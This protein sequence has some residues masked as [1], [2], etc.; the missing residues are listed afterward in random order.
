MDRIRRKINPNDVDE[1]CRLYDWIPSGACVRP[2]AAVRAEKAQLMH[3]ALVRYE[4]ARD[5]VLNR[6]FRLECSSN[7]FASALHVDRDVEMSA[8]RTPQERR[9]GRV[10]M[11]VF[12]ANP[13]PYSVPPNTVHSVL[14]CLLDQDEEEE[15]H[16]GDVDLLM[17]NA[18]VD[19][20]FQECNGDD[21]EVRQQN[22]CDYLNS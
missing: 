10:R 11:F 9:E 22:Y 19:A 17:Q 16:E 7:G 21:F 13:F 5:Y 8:R 6:V 20:L 14:W 12:A 18:I 15:P 2:S 4:T 3:N 1:L